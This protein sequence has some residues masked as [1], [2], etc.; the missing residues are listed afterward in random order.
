MEFHETVFFFNFFYSFKNSGSL[1]FWKRMKG[2]ISS[3]FSIFILYEK[4]S[5]FYILGN[6]KTDAPF[7]PSHL[8]SMKLKVCVKKGKERKF[9]KFIHKMFFIYFNV[10]R[11]RNIFFLNFSTLSRSF[12]L[13]LIHSFINIFLWFTYNFY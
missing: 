7:P 8:H 1:N 4:V 11:M 6:L 10:K 3:K 12:N 5:I 13:I 2:A 9:E